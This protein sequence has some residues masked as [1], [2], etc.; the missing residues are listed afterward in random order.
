MYVETI[1]HQGSCVLLSFHRSAALTNGGRGRWGPWSAAL[2]Q[3]EWWRSPRTA[4]ASRFFRGKWRFRGCVWKWGIQRGYKN[5][6]YLFNG[7]LNWKMMTKYPFF[8]A[9]PHMLTYLYM[10]PVNFHGNSE[11]LGSTDH[12]N[13]WVERAENK[14]YLGTCQPE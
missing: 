2:C 8:G 5:V 4:E 12:S 13:H 14:K 9:K 1:V 3:I 6:T 11:K 7:P 10:D